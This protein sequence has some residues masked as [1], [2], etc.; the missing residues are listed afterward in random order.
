MSSVNKQPWTFRAI[1]KKYPNKKPVDILKDL[2]AGTPGNEGKRFAG[3]GEGAARIQ[4]D[5]E[6]KRHRRG[7]GAPTVPFTGIIKD[8]G[9]KFRVPLL[10][11]YG[12]SPAGYG[13]KPLLFQ[14]CFKEFYFVWRGVIPL[15]P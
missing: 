11:I 4:A 13:K 3:A 2:V 12:F 9:P 6:P 14:V 1:I 5:A 10:H 8:P 15:F 7:F